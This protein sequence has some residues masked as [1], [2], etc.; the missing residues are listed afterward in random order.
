MSRWDL[1]LKN[2]E[3]ALVEWDKANIAYDVAL[4]AARTEAEVR[5]AFKIEDDAKEALAQAFFKDTHDRNSLDS[6]RL[7]HP[8]TLREWVNKWIAEGRPE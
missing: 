8:K 5:K 4:H 2:T 7:V 3:A 6:C 1:S